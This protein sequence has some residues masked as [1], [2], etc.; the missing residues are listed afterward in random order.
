MSIKCKIF[1]L[2]VGKLFSVWAVLGCGIGVGVGG[3]NLVRSETRL[4]YWGR[5]SDRALS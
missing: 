2:L 1:T 3:V 5:T 4:I